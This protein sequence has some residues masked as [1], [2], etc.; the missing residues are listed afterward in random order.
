M[1]IVLECRRLVRSNGLV[2]PLTASATQA[3]FHSLELLKSLQWLLPLNSLG[4]VIP[5]AS[6]SVGARC[7]RL[8]VP[9]TVRCELPGTRIS[10]YGITDNR[11]KRDARTCS[12][13]ART[14]RD[15]DRQIRRAGAGQGGA[16]RQS[17]LPSPPVGA[18]VVPCRW[19]STMAVAAPAATTAPAAAQNPQRR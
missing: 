8:K 17:M 10:D 7:N 15:S 1:A 14:V 19:L 16:Q 9:S 5:I 4:T 6:S 18:D 11:L 2:Q 13:P 3:S 12:P